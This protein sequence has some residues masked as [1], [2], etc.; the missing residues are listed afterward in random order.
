MDILQISSDFWMG[1]LAL[2]SF[3]WELIFLSLLKEK[4]V[5][6][7]DGGGGEGKETLAML[8]TPRGKR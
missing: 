3:T 8:Y 6:C 7:D 5:A 2:Y 4:V 1:S